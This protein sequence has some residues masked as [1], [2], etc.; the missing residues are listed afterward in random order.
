MSD[1]LVERLR[2]AE[3]VAV[4]TGA[5][6]SAESGVPTFRDA[7]TGLWANYD[8]AE[9][10]TPQAFLRNP[11]LVWDWYAYRRQTVEAAQPNEAHYALVD[12]EQHYSDFTLITQNIDSLH[13]RAGSRDLL[14]L[15][16]NISR[17]RCFECAT[18]APGWD[19]EGELP[20][21]CARC[22]GLLRPDVVWFGE[23]L[24]DQ[25]LRLAYEAAQRSQVFLS[26]GTSAIVQPAASLP[27]I[28]RRSGAYLIEINVEETS[29]SVFADCWLQDQAGT[30][31]P[32]LV[33]R[34]IR[35][36]QSREE[37]A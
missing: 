11:R 28:A 14:E 8:P 31:L 20:P 22:G 26:V 9:L 24:P 3:H 19:E 5:G 1:E 36:I 10:A 12:L 15:H 27:L 21:R 4:L 37:G 33:R 13:W 18:Y 29:L 35:D 32:E 25:A 30:V 16:G 2:A 34:V 7:Q 23:G 17:V 6:V